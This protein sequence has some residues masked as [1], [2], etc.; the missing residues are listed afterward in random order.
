M[1]N[2]PTL[3]VLHGICNLIG[4]GVVVFNV[5]SGAFVFQVFVETPT[6]GQLLHL[7]KCV[8]MVCMCVCMCVCIWCV[9]VRVCVSSHLNNMHDKL[10]WNVVMSSSIQK[11]KTEA[12]QK[13]K[14][15]KVKNF[16]LHMSN[17]QDK[18]MHKHHYPL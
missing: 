13:V 15:L 12:K 5:Q 3:Q 10:N 7:S 6:W 17:L 16:N 2:S 9:C 8:C 14:L 4:I 1:N 18:S 11:Y